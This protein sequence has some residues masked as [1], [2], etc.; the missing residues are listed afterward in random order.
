MF[1]RKFPAILE[2][3][4]PLLTK[5]R[6]K[7]RIRSMMMAQAMLLFTFVDCKTILYGFHIRSI[8]SQH[9]LTSSSSGFDL[10]A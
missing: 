7:G 1:V 9:G 5:L 10:S 8:Q 3:L 6:K 2:P 4:L